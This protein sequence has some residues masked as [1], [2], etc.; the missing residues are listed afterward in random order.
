MSDTPELPVEF[1]ARVKI[2]E[3][4]FAAFDSKH[5]M[6]ARTIP[7]GSKVMFQV[8]LDHEEGSFFRLY[9][10]ICQL[11]N[12]MEAIERTEREKKEAEK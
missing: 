11:K 6:G 4:V 2:T 3:N 10:P 12:L 7:M 5:I 8:D 1:E 9:I